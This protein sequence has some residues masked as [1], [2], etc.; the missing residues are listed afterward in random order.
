MGFL[1][2]MEPA[3][4]RASGGASL[5]LVILIFGALLMVG[6]WWGSRMVRR[7][8]ERGKRSSV[9]LF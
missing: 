5:G 7:G 6:V 4:E 9:C 1:P 3:S 8:M 2:P